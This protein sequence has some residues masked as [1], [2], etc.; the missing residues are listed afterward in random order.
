MFSLSE[1]KLTG[2]RPVISSS[3]VPL[4]RHEGFEDFG[5]HGDPQGGHHKDTPDGNYRGT[6]QQHVRDPAAPWNSHVHGTI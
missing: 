1:L 3:H 4:Q 6:R 2:S 5:K